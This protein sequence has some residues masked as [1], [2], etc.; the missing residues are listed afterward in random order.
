MWLIPRTRRCEIADR[1][2]RTSAILYRQGRGRKRDL[3][4][5]SLSPSLSLPEPPDRP[6]YTRATP[7]GARFCRRGILYMQVYTGSCRVQALRVQPPGCVALR[8]WM[9]RAR[10]PETERDAQAGRSG[11]SGGSRL[12]G[13]RKAARGEKREGW[14]GWGTGE[15]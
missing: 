6:R 1:G 4:P 12:C 5:P 14:E 9:H 15:G 13:G 10:I 2:K 7:N 11:G 3:I 8:G